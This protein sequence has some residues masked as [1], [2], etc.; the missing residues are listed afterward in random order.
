MLNKFLIAILLLGLSAVALAADLYKW[1]DEKGVIHYSD[2][3]PPQQASAARLRVKS[4][5]S[6][7]SAPAADASDNDS[8]KNKDASK[9][10]ATAA[11]TPADKTNCDHAHANLNLLTQ[12]KYQVADASGKPLDDKTRQEMTEQAKQAVAA[13]DKT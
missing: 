13:C 11:Q 6:D 7:E 5:V 1:T 12:S 10:A 8:N 4:G 9:P 3:P 2:T